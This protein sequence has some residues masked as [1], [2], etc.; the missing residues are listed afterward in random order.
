MYSL[1]RWPRAQRGST[2]TP[3]WLAS[4]EWLAPEVVAD[5]PDGTERRGSIRRPDKIKEKAANSS[6]LRVLQSKPLI[7]L[8]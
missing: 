8:L 2:E 4:V 6:G 3:R 1:R 7:L 5:G